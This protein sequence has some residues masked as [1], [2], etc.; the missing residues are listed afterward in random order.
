MSELLVVPRH[1]ATDKNPLEGKI[2]LFYQKTAT[3]LGVLS[4]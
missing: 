2:V 4:S 1:F 3:P